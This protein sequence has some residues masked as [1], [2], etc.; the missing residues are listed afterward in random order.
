M[1]VTQDTGRHGLAAGVGDVHVRRLEDQVADGKDET[2][3]V[4]E[5]AA[6][7]PQRTEGSGRARLRRHLR[8][9]LH[10][11]VEGLGGELLAGDMR[12]NRQNKNK[13]DEES[14]PDHGTPPG[15][16]RLEPAPAARSGYTRADP[17]PHLTA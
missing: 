1:I 15:R 2:V 12:R 4:D 5:D 3:G 7:F 11:G 10:H 9:D 8:A 13:D 14:S 6:A 17:C 16:P